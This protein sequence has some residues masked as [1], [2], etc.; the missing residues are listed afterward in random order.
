MPP[1]A[2]DVRLELFVVVS[3]VVAPP[4]AGLVDVTCCLRMSDAMA[5]ALAA[6]SIVPAIVPSFRK[7]RFPVDVAVI[8][9]AVPVFVTLPSAATGDRE[10]VSTDRLVTV[11][12]PPVVVA[13]VPLSLVCVVLA[14]PAVSPSVPVTVPALTIVAPASPRANTLPDMMPPARTVAVACPPAT[15]WLLVETVRSGVRVRAVRVSKPLAVAERAGAPESGDT[16][17]RPASVTD[18]APRVLL[19]DTEPTTDPVAP[20]VTLATPPRALLLLC[21]VSKDPAAEE[22]KLP[23]DVPSEPMD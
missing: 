11:V 20:I 9:P 7:L 12:T 4:A 3:T 19:A 6:R 14:A 1:I 8:A 17:A 18:A 13:A 10:K 16:P 21:E 2:R 15:V 5:S 23:D 22:E